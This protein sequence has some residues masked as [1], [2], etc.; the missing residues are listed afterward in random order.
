MRSNKKISW[1]DLA[2]ED[3]ISIRTYISKESTQNANK[4]FKQILNSVDDLLQL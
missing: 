2:V 1:T 3:L 4:V